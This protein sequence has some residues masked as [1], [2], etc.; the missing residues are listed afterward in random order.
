MEGL[1]NAKTS[2]DIEQLT[3]NG[4]DVNHQLFISGYWWT[5]L[6]W[7]CK[8]GNLDVVKSLLE[9][10]AKWV[11]SII[12][13]SWSPIWAAAVEG[14]IDVVDYLL[15][16]FIW[17]SLEQNNL[18]LY[19]IRNNRHDIFDFLVKK[20]L[21]QKDFKIYD[22]SL[23]HT[24]VKYGHIDLII[25]LLDMGFSIHD[26]DNDG[27]TPLLIAAVNGTTNCVDHLLCHGADFND[28]DYRGQNFLTLYMKQWSDDFVDIVKKFVD[29]GC[30]LN[31][32]NEFELCE[33]EYNSY[34]LVKYLIDNGADDTIVNC[35]GK[36]CWDVFNIY[37]GINKTVK[38]LNRQKVLEYIEYLKS[39]GPACRPEWL[40]AEYGPGGPT[41]PI[42]PTGCRTARRIY[43]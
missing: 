13:S 18:I 8:N 21:L 34:E 9:H 30:D 15:E 27:R 23:L 41:G 6:T 39:P 32:K 22:V 24:A 14:H 12:I 38:N 11:S 17:D 29:L 1:F 7:A 3:K 16:I 25:K 36:T 42:G 2:S 5:P 40:S 43:N 26:R 28:K 35:D 4:C 31:C 10:N 37:T 19:C 33:R 20:G